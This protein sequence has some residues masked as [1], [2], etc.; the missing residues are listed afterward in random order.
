[1]TQ[2]QTLYT[3][4]QRPEGCTGMEIIREC[5][6]TSPSKRLSEARSLGWKIEKRK[7]SGKNYHTF[8][9]EMPK[10]EPV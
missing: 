7:V 3:L 8:H 4:L 6:T 2:L 5:K 10:K 1:M 9:G